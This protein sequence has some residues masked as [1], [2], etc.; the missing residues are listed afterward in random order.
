[1]KLFRLLPVVPAALLLAGCGFLGLGATSLQAA[2]QDIPFTTRFDDVE[3]SE[4]RFLQIAGLDVCT[5]GDDVRITGVQMLGSGAPTTTGFRISRSPG[6]ENE[7]DG[8]SRVGPTPPGNTSKLETTE[9]FSQPCGD[10]GRAALTIDTRIGDLPVEVDTVRVT[11]EVGDDEK[12]ADLAVN[13]VVCNGSVG[14]PPDPDDEN[15]F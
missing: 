12:V 11:Y 14:C 2:D 9:S 13:L 10:K 5:G 6:S 8:S 3:T 4:A 1:M 15:D 7:S